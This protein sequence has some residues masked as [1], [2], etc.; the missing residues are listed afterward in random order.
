[1]SLFG[2]SCSSDDSRH[3]PADSHVSLWPKT[4]LKLRRETSGFTPL[5][6]KPPENVAKSRKGLFAFDPVAALQNIIFA[7]LPLRSHA[8]S[9]TCENL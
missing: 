3:G 9:L 4:V 1:M 8:D 6:V 2:A 5:S 7:N